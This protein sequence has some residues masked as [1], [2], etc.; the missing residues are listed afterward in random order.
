M[1]T[2]KAQVFEDPAMHQQEIL[3]LLNDNLGIT[4]NRMKQEA[5]QHCIEREFEVGIGYL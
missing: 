2:A 1:G 4:Q 3:K 5:S